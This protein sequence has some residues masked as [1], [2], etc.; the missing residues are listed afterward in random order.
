MSVDA[1]AALKTFEA[2][3]NITEGIPDEMYRF[4]AAK[5]EALRDEAPWTA[6]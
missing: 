6:E 3:N 4:D 2:A 1:A 5:D